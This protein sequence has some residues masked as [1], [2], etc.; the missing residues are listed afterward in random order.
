MAKSRRRSIYPILLIALVNGLVFAGTMVPLAYHGFEEGPP[1]DLTA[2]GWVGWTTLVLAVAGLAILVVGGVLLRAIPKIPALTMAVYPASVAAV[3]LIGAQL[4]A[5]AVKQTLDAADPSQRL[6]IFGV[7]LFEALNAT[8]VTQ[9]VAAMLMMGGALTISLRHWPSRSSLSSG[10]KLGLLGGGFM[11]VGMIVGSF[12]WAPLGGLGILPWVTTLVGLV[13]IA[14]A[15]HAIRND[16]TDEANLQAAGEL[17]VTLLLAVGAL[18]FV[19]SAQHTGALVQGLAVFRDPSGQPETSKLVEPWTAAGPSLYASALYAVP[20]LFAAVASMLSRESLGSWGLR[21]AAASIFVIPVF[22]AAPAA[23][24]YVQ[25]TWAANQLAKHVAC[26]AHVVSNPDLALPTTSADL[27]ADCP[28]AVLELGRTHVMMGKEKLALTSDLDKPEGCAAVAAKVEGFGASYAGH[29]A[30]DETLPYRRAACVAEALAGT[31][32]VKQKSALFQQLHPD[33][34]GRKGEVL[35]WVLKAS[36]EQV[37]KGR[38]PF[39]ALG[40]RLLGAPA[41]GPA[42][43]GWDEKLVML[44]VFEGGW[45]LQRAPGAKPIGFRGRMDEGVE[46]LKTTLGANYAAHAVVLRADPDVRMGML[47]QYASLF[48]YPQL[49]VPKSFRDDPAPEASTAGSAAPPGSAAPAGSGAPA[50]S[51][52][53]P[54]S[55]APLGSAAPAA[56]P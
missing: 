11:L 53:V 47:L 7:G 52:A 44:R 21:N 36:G 50:A 1:V 48:S 55:A 15:A 25:T 31:D 9:Y 6:S 54:G 40:T 14:L 37:G 30:T 56:S 3:G 23:L 8:L 43:E 29:V 2:A 49:V 4:G 26:P 51:A 16:P 46:R 34:I 18:V 19:C 28:A 32:A 12:F 13:A 10:G 38:P 27:P 24:A 42:A 20:L 22:F 33:V 5:G 45:E 17:W 41:F 35:S 39:D